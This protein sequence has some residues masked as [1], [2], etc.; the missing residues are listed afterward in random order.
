MRAERRVL[1]Q[2][3]LA[4]ALWIIAEGRV[5]P[6]RDSGVVVPYS[7]SPYAPWILTRCGGLWKQNRIGQS[8]VQ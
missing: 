1:A 8:G 2:Q 6:A 3:Q 5:H 4:Q 7:L